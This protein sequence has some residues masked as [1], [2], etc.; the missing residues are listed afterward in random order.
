MREIPVPLSQQSAPK[1]FT[2]SQSGGPIQDT[3]AR[4]ADID[5]IA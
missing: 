3:A 5:S 2:G 1:A 4:L